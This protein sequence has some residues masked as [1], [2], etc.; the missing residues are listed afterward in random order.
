M[1]A[2]VM[3]ILDAS[4]IF[5]AVRGILYMQIGASLPYMWTKNPF[6]EN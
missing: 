6:T 2:L 3:Y 5:Y 4:T 1:L